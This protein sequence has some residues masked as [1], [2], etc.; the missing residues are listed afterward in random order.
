MTT[1]TLFRRIPREQLPERFLPAWDAMRQLTGEPTFV[2]VFAAAPELADFVMNEFYAKVF[3]G[4]RVDQRYKQIAR[5][6]LSIAHGCHTCNRQ[7]VPGALAAGLTRA[8]VDAMIEGRVDAGLFSE[9]E[10]AVMEY[11]DQVALTNMAGDVSPE[12]F[13]ALRR[14]FSEAEILE[15]GVTMAVIAGMAKLSFL[16]RLVEKEPYC[17]FVPGAA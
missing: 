14:H 4:G 1:D 15:L 2:E 13:A 17:P 10:R 8:Q 12:L 11:A 9:A 16:L 6:K 3:F 5:L 7:N